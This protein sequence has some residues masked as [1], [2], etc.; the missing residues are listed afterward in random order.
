MST[1]LIH[2]TGVTAAGTQTTP[3][4]DPAGQLSMPVPLADS[5][6]GRPDSVG[7]LSSLLVPASIVALVPDQ[8]AAVPRWEWAGS[9][10][11]TQCAAHA[12]V[13][14]RQ[15]G[16]VDLVAWVDASSRA[17][18]L[19]GLASAGLR[20]GLDGDGGAERAAARFVAWLR[21]T[22]QRC[23]VVLDDL[24]HQDDV[25]DLWP[26]GPAVITLVTARDPAVVAGSPARVVPVGCYSQ[27]E[28][29]AA[30]SAWLSADPDQR[31]GHLD[32][33]LA[34]DCE[35]AAIA[36]AGAVIATAE[37]TCR[38]YHE[39]FL[40]RRAVIEQAAG[41]EVPAMTTPWR[42]APWRPPRCWPP[43][44]PTTR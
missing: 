28:A 43:G 40:R 14:L 38:S 21:G 26:A 37:L 5:F 18:L 22:T 42:P 41:G 12:A 16:A 15:S 13:H 7:D 27:R 17:S 36:Q 11:K 2:A 29:I 25:A 33:V 9:H 1:T 44:R 3:V 4:Q 10:G 32:L 30:L 19:D 31:S 6:A 35:P 34:L 8:L 23:L 24:R 39:L 20:A